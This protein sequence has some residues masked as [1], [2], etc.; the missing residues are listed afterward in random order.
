MMPASPTIAIV[1]GGMAGLSCAQRLRRM[2]HDVQVFDK[3]RGPG[4]RVCTRHDATAG[5]FDH[6]AQFVTVRDPDFEIWINEGIATGS[7]ARAA[8]R[9]RRPDR[10]PGDRED[11]TRWVGSP[12]M[13]ALA[14][15]LVQ[16][17]SVER[18][19]R[20]VGLQRHGQD[21]Y[22]DAE[23]G[24]RW[25]PF[26]QVVLAVPAP[27]AHELLEPVAPSLAARV[28]Q[29]RMAPCW[30]LMVSWDEP[31]DLPFDAMEAEHPV[32]AW[33]ARDASKPGRDSGERWVLHAGASWSHTH[34]EAPAEDVVAPLLAA[35]DDWAGQALPAPRHA[36]AHRWRYAKVVEALGVQGLL[37]EGLGLAACGDW[38]RGSR[39]ED[40]WLSGWHTAAWLHRAAL[41]RVA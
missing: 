2:G 26:T 31:L 29:A 20:I 10:E 25:G 1:G 3:G 22:L 40:A 9:L 39:V 37:D 8:W 7:V 14:Q 27:Q 21:W 38:C 30:A 5:N 13:S 11:P 41:P 28:A 36:R 4:G 33:V 15:A 34:L 18:G 17:L 19:V 12:S 32:L 35:F 16:D 23:G 24:Q 6:G